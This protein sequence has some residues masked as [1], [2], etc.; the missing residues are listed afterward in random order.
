MSGRNRNEG[1]GCHYNGREALIDLFL[2]LKLFVKSEL[3]LWGVK[4]WGLNGGKKIRILSYFVSWIILLH[5]QYEE[6]VTLDNR[7]IDD[8][9]K[10]IWKEAAAA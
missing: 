9:L 2:M 7:M 10:R 4:I 8:E 1:P 3:E 6:Y 5:F